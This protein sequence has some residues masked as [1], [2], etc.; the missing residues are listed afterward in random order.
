MNRNSWILLVGLFA[1]VV[2]LIC[3]LHGWNKRLL[4][5]HAF[6]QTQ[7]AISTYYMVE[8]G[9]AIDYQTP[10]LGKPWQ[11]PMEFP[12]YQLLVASLVKVSKAPLEQTGRFVSMLFFYLS[13]LSCLLI[14][15]QWTIDASS[16]GHRICDPFDEPA[17]YMFWSTFM[18][19]SMAL[20]L[21]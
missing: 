10:V 5:L 1:V 19:E 15:R 2:Q 16:D 18:I 17:L 3:S 7:T 13:I 9:L 6:R 14:L 11:I 8:E 20:C 21:H 12:S 4:D